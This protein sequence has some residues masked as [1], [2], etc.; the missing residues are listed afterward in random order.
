MSR[1]DRVRT[2][3]AAAAAAAALL[4]LLLLLGSGGSGCGSSSQ[5]SLNQDMPTGVRVEAWAVRSQFENA[6]QVWPARLD[7]LVSRGPRCR[8]DAELELWRVEWSAHV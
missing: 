5:L 7:E 4:L 1:Q 6:A 3:A 8:G 2:R